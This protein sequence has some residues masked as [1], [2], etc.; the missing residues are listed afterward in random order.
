MRATVF[1]TEQCLKTVTNTDAIFLLR[2]TRNMKKDEH[3]E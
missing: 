2:Q 1:K 3:D